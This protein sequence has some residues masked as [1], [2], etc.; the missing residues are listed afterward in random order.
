VLPLRALR[1]LAP[2]VV[3]AAAAFAPRPA[4]GVPVVPTGFVDELV[5][6]PLDAPTNSCLMPDGRIFVVEQYTAQVRLVVHGAMSA[7]DPAGVVP[8][9][10]SGGEAGLLGVAVDPGFPARP[11][12]YVQGTHLATSTVRIWRYTLTG[13]LAFTGNGAMALDPASQYLVLANGPDLNPS[14]NGGTLRFGPD[15][16]LY[17][18]IGDD[19]NSCLAQS[20]ST[21]NGKILRLDVSQLP[22]GGGGPPRYATITPAD[23]PFVAH[24]D[25][26]ARLVWAWGLRNPFSFTIDPPT[27]CLH[28]GDVGSQQ[29]EEVDIVCAAGRNFGWPHYEGAHRTTVQCPGIDTTQ[30][31]PPSHEYFHDGAGWAVFSGP[32]YRLP[33]GATSPFP[34]EYENTYFYGDT[35]RSVIRRLVPAGGGAWTPAAAV[36]GQP[37]ATDWVTGI[38]YITSMFVG[39]DGSL[40]YTMLYRVE[41][42][43]GPGELRRIRYTESL[44]GVGDGGVAAGVAFVAARP[45]PA[46]RTA[47]VELVWRQ[48]RPG[49]VTLTVLDV[50][51]RTVRA[52]LGTAAGVRAAGEHRLAWDGRDALG[53]VAGAGVYVAKLEAQGTVRTLR[54]VRL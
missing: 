23:N 53:R 16:R 10:R 36:P 25:T 30:F 39:P 49:P 21:L 20:L 41:P 48:A 40:Y 27:G 44:V 38:R 46:Q 7:I 42:A 29:W 34:A 17:S 8:G 18:S 4:G 32:L 47:P 6:A 14:H 24:P 12:V 13:D 37:N 22:P 28:I 51:G 2:L 26:V 19:E 52:L 31:V 9:I 35:W 5:V 1:A 3:V 33:P 50:R 45:T 15:G 54:L 11:Y 43:N